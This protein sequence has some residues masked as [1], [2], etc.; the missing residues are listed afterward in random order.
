MQRLLR[1]TLSKHFRNIQI[2]PYTTQKSNEIKS[3]FF[4]IQD[5]FYRQSVEYHPLD[6]IFHPQSV[7]VIGA[8]D[9]EHSVGRNVMWSLL[10]NPF[11]G[12]VFPVNNKRKSVMGIVAY[13][14]IKDVPIPVDLAIVCIPAPSVP[15]I[16]RECA[17]AKVKGMIIISAGFQEAGEQGKKWFQEIQEISRQSKMRIIGPNC[18]GIINTRGMNASFAPHTKPIKGSVAI[19]SQS[20]ALGTAILDWSVRE[21]VGLS[22]LVTLGSMV[23]VS[24]SDLLEYFGRDVH[25]KSIILYM[26]GIGESARKFVAAARKVAL[27]KPI[28]LI[29]AGVTTEG[30]KAAASHTGALAGSDE[31]MSALFNR[32]GVLRVE[33]IG[34]LFYCA[35]ALAKQPL[36]K[37]NRLTIITNAG[38]PAALSVDTLV[39]R[40]GILA[41]LSEKIMEQLN[42]VLPSPWSHANP[43]DI[44]GDA[45]AERYEKALDILTKN[46][47]SDGILIIFTPQ[48]MSEPTQTAQF[49]ASRK[50]SPEKPI[51]ASFMGGEMVEEANQ[52][53]SKASIP[54]FRFPDTAARVFNY[55]YQ[56]YKHLKNLYE[57]PKSMENSSSMDFN[58]KEQAKQF[59]EKIQKDGRTLLNEYESKKLL[60]IYNIPTTEIRVC[61]DID[62]A[63]KIANEIGYPV[64]L[65]IISDTI[66]HK[67]D[68]G[69]VKLN[70]KN[71]EEVRKAFQ[72]IQSSIPEHDLQGIS[73]QPM[74]SFSDSYNLFIGSSAD[75][76]CGPVI[77]C[78][79]G[80]TLVELY[81]G[82]ILYISLFI[83]IDTIQEFPPLTL[84]LAKRMLSK[85]K[86][87]RALCGYRGQKPVDL[88]ALEKILVRFSQLVLDLYQLIKEIDINPLLV[89]SEGIIALDAR[90]LIYPIEKPVNEIP[91]PA[92][93][94]Y[95]DH[96]ISTI[97]KRIQIRPIGAF[98]QKILLEFFESSIQQ[99]L[100]MTNEDNKFKEI[101]QEFLTHQEGERKKFIHDIAVRLCMG[102]F[103]NQ[104]SLIAIENDKI[105]G[106]I[107]YTKSIR[108]QTK[109][110]IA[111]IFGKE[112]NFELRKAMLQKM[113][114]VAKNEGIQT[115]QGDFERDNEDTI[116][117]CRECKF[118]IEE[119]RETN[120][121]TAR[122][123][124]NK[125]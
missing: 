69:G 125:E 96:Y 41:P 113:I 114:L 43:V 6:K 76:Q 7:A 32:C 77:V 99:L 52:I 90:V 82:I 118:R 13:P 9:R 84:S 67:S 1:H 42:K 15:Q 50:L 85:T 26:E 11:G 97:D 91:E 14:S 106:L 10:S 28:I 101:V 71:D 29:K 100:E 21:N 117:L 17:D 54:N 24:W 123:Y 39:R 83:V 110:Y 94:P 25:T 23:D 63:V 119:N 47:E 5:F 34:E 120:T 104:M 2:T 3:T 20:G 70:L 92:F 74:I 122:L 46:P 30:V 38:G 12:V 115:L 33:T 103:D 68:V 72:S 58:W 116:L 35:E 65:K 75:E 64:V 55:G 89:S 37:D 36:P 48:A 44:L 78:G 27:T 81:K 18:L 98:D 112:M 22:S 88:D 60:E 79:S 53:L 49:I 102:D 86:I 40:G 56:Y 4:N 105:L 108:D 95:P 31:V 57:V 16:V 124:I 19:I 61:N 45:T 93:R 51:Y 87:Y 8:T 111:M 107:T 59:L 66:I 62:S 109:A 73:V 80:G 121:M